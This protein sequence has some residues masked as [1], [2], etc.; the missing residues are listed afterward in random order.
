MQGEDERREVVGGEPEALK[1]REQSPVRSGALQHAPS[2]VPKKATGKPEAKLERKL[3]QL[4]MSLA[5]DSPA[6]RGPNRAYLCG[7]E[8]APSRTVPNP[9]SSSWTL[10]GP[11]AR[12]HLPY[13]LSASRSPQVPR[14][15][16]TT[17]VYLNLQ[18]DD[19][20]YRY[21]Y[22]EGANKHQRR[23]GKRRAAVSSVLLSPLHS[24]ADSVHAALSKLS[25]LVALCTLRR[26]ENVE[27]VISHGEISEAMVVA[28]GEERTTMFV[29]LLVLCASI[30]G[31]LFGTCLVGHVTRQPH[32]LLVRRL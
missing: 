6:M 30:S 29:W 15:A 9:S 17:V 32:E 19:L 2:D 5:S 21:V 27:N 16:C 7:T 13:R 23:E 24:H 12:V 26:F 14:V 22:G 3:Q 1:T 8:V 25:L 11:Q 10:L 4:L 31:L 28:E 18:G 20:N